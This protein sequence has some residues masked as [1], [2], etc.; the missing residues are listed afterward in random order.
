MEN[1]FRQK[2]EK[3]E[4]KNITFLCNVH[5]VTEP[6][7][8]DVF[9]F[10]FEIVSHSFIFVA[11]YDAHTLVLVFVAMM[12][13]CTCA[14]RKPSPINVLLCRHKWFGS[15]VFITCICRLFLLL[16]SALLFFL[17][18]TAA[19]DSRNIVCLC[20]QAQSTGR[21]LS[22]LTQWNIALRRDAYHYTNETGD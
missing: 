14:V 15:L 16:F 3:I 1:D 13:V 21:R 19:F 4:P 6:V 12:I 2:T 18:P 5:F 11:A 8:H 7:R 17:L 22:Q 20:F 10:S 9:R